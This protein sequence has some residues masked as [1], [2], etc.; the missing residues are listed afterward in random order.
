VGGPREAI[1]LYDALHAGEKAAYSRRLYPTLVIVAIIAIVVATR[2]GETQ[3][4]IT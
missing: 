3:A 4:D 1:W 2:R